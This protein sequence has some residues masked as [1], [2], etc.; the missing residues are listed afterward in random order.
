M[1]LTIARSTFRKA[2]AVLAVAAG[3]FGPVA[4]LAQTQGG[5]LTAIVQ[6]EPP[7]LMLGLNQQAPTQYVAGKIY[8]SLLTYD[9]AL[10]PLP[11]LAKSWKTSSDGLTYTFELQRG[12]KWHDGKPFT[13]ADVVFSVDKFLRETHPRGRL[14]INK[15]IESVTAIN[16]H[17]VE[18]KLK[19][20][21]SPFMSFGLPPVSRT[22]PMT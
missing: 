7:T 16:E 5:T 11:S 4:A 17:T 13:A 10:Q 3:L 6:P 21:F 8:Q 20:A 14:V 1:K 2:G 19:E 12:V 15:Y 22:H 9:A 18:F